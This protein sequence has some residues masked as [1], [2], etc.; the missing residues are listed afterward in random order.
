MNIQTPPDQPDRL[1]L[2]MVAIAPR[3]RGR[4]LSLPLNATA[5]ERMLNGSYVE[6]RPKAA[7]RYVRLLTDDWRLPAIRSYLRLGFEP[8]VPNGE[9]DLQARWDAVYARISADRAAGETGGGR[10]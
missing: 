6:P 2:H 7:P 1:L 4:G 9:S 5:L 3:W 8:L 10:A